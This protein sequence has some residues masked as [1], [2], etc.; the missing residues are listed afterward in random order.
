MRVQARSLPRVWLAACFLAGAAAVPVADDLAAKAQRGREA[1]AAGRFDEAATLYAEIT[2]ALPDEPGMLLNLGMALSM[3]GRPREAVPR[4]EAALRLRPDLL[5]ASLFLGAARLELGQPARAL[6]PLQ[7]VVAAQPDNLEARRRLADALWSLERFAPAVQEYQTLA[8]Q[9][10]DDPRA[11][12][13]L[14]KSYEGLARVALERLQTSAPDTDYVLRLVADTMVAEGRLANA[15]R[16]YREALEKRPSLAEAHDA[17]A[18]IY[19]DSGHPEWAA[20]ERERSRAIPPLDCP[21]PSPQCDFRARRYA[22]VLATA[23]SLG[24]AE[25]LYWESR[26]AREL[27]AEAFARL[28]HLAP[29]A[30]A[31]LRHVEVLRSRKRTAAREA[32]DELKKAAQAWPEDLRIRRELATV[33]VIVGDTETAQAILEEL[34]KREPESAEAA[35]A[36]GETWLKVQQPARAIPLLEGVVRRDPKL[37]LAQAALGRAYAEAGDMAKAIAPLQAALETD[38]DGSL[39]YQLARAYRATGR[40]ELATQALAQFQE[41][42]K[43]AEAQAQSLQEEFR[44]TPP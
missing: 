4:L 16:L 20:V 35:L 43:S 29:S 39:H 44:I 24:T 14:G 8:G 34:L 40:S 26:A 22:S 15:F 28:D 3:A 2:R 1:M 36:L 38:Q 31:T 33:L 30:E 6:E 21:A 13:G 10:P 37:L 25:G 41:I 17:L 9:A 12:Y 18:R 11:W 32:I 42:R 5:P 7:K 27:A 23:G 19:E